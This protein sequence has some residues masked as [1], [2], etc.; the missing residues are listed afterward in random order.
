[1]HEGDVLCT[2]EQLASAG[3]MVV[4]GFRTSLI[5]RPIKSLPIFRRNRKRDSADISFP[6][7][8]QSFKY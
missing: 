3:N 5:S 7:K 6:N 8:A 4:L 2:L 1:M